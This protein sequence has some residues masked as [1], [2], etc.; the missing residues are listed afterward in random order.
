MA[1]L[2]GASKGARVVSPIW[3]FQHTLAS[4]AGLERTAPSLL[5]DVEKFLVERH[6]PVGLFR[7]LWRVSVAEMWLAQSDAIAP[8]VP[9]LTPQGEIRFFSAAIL[10]PRN[11]GVF[12]KG[13]W[14]GPS[15]NEERCTPHPNSSQTD[16]RLGT[17][18]NFIDP[19]PAGFEAPWAKL[20][21]RDVRAGQLHSALRVFLAG[22]DDF[23]QT[24]SQAKV[25]AIWMFGLRQYFDLLCIP[26]IEVAARKKQ[27]TRAAVSSH[28]RTRELKERA[29]SEYLA[30]RRK[31]SESG[32]KRMSRADFARR[33]A[34]KYG[35]AS[36]RTVDIWLHHAETKEHLRKL[37]PD[38]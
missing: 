28:R 7:A 33:F 24:L 15:E 31:E 17:L 13:I 16:P 25:S 23:G 2:E 14:T 19:A 30:H 12:R 27:A 10:H 3:L 36:A 35:G 20:T 29:A 22:K 21:E 6:I 18:L 38:G 32:G 5:A 34:E 8:G 11:E 37:F 4:L 26:H 1:I 9:N